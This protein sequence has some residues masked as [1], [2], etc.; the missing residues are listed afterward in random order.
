MWQ[1]GMKGYFGVRHEIILLDVLIKIRRFS[2][3]KFD[4]HLDVTLA[5]HESHEERLA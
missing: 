5:D 2:S 1:I 3:Q 4:C